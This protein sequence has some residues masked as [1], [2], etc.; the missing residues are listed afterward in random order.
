MINRLLGAASGAAASERQASPP[1][2]VAPS[3][4]TGDS[5]SELLSRFVK[6]GDA[7]AF[8][9]IVSRYQRLV[10]GVAWRHVA[11]RHLAE[12]VFQA[13]FLVLAEQARRIR[14][15][16]SLASWLHGTARR[17]GLRALSKT[18]RYSVMHK[19]IEESAA[20]SAEL[21]QMESAFEQQV[22]DEE[23]SN[24]PDRWRQPLV[25]HYL[26]G[27][28]AGEVAGRLN[29]SVFA[30]EGRLKKG[31]DELRRRLMRHGVGFGAIMTA[32]S[33]ASESAAAAPSAQVVGST[34]ASCVSWT[35]N[36]SVEACSAN[37]VHLAGKE[38]AAMTAS[39]SVSL[40]AGTAIFCLGT[41]VLAAWPFGGGGPQA[42]GQ[43]AVGTLQGT[44]AAAAAQ[45][46]AAAPATVTGTATGSVS[47]PAP[48]SVG[49][50]ANSTQPVPLAPDAARDYQQLG[51]SRKRVEEVLDQAE[52]MRPVSR[53]P[54]SE[55]VTAIRGEWSIPVQV[56]QS[57]LDDLGFSS[58]ELLG[59]VPTGLGARDSLELAL[60]SIGNSEL[61]YIID[62]GV[63]KITTTEVAEEH[64]ETV[65]YELRHLGSNHPARDVMDLVMQTIDGPWLDVDGDGGT[66]VALPGAIAVRQTQR[67]HREIRDLLRQLEQF[68]ARPDMPAV[69]REPPQPLGGDGFGQGFGGGGP[70]GGGLGGGGLGGASGAGGSGFFS[71]PVDV[72]AVSSEAGGGSSKSE[73]RERRRARRNQR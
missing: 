37:A 31:R 10:M 46:P 5:D 2:E 32:V 11:D 21:T 27:L 36:Q 54:L 25:L 50:V 23:L 73:R 22:L 65:I 28:T 8:E 29:L 59:D 39:K 47:R 62:H 57:A 20:D 45:P 4:E 53:I 42:A 64:R 35:T 48:G 55:F 7:E 15:R 9:S 56:D 40:L 38:I 26:Q 67:V 66:I 71:G 72:P 1:K 68:T 34:V 51:D 63:L 61:S 33:A 3:V 58:D 17:I 18:R 69:K 13:T 52:L 30:V 41:G 43:G 19:Q 24:L 44:T 70:G 12:D 16:G 49:T 6:T 60:E 14:K